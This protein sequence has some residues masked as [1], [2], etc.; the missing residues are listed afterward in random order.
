M[1]ACSFTTETIVDP[2]LFT[3]AENC[4]LSGSA[5]KLFGI[6]ANEAPGARNGTLTRV[7]HPPSANL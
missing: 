5:G 2:K 3:T 4:E 7:T 1:P 6:S